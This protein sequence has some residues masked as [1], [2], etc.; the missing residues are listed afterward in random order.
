[1]WRAVLALPPILLFIWAW[2]MEEHP[3]REC[4][5]WEWVTVTMNGRHIGNGH[6]G[7][8]PHKVR[9]CVK[10]VDIPE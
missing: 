2:N 9:T 1:M 5:E 4:V 3:A 7:P 10:W 6:T 8:M